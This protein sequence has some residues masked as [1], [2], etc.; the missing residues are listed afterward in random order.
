[1]AW[2]REIFRYFSSFLVR[3]YGLRWWILSH[4]QNKKATRSVVRHCHTRTKGHIRIAFFNEHAI[5]RYHRFT[6]T[7]VK[8]SKVEIK[9]RWLACGDVTIEKSHN[10][11]CRIKWVSTR[12]KM[13]CVMIM[14]IHISKDAYRWKMKRESVSKP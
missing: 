14:F 4:R 7:H 12:H 5:E 9:K 10:K 3:F 8:S 6:N 11:L 1:M 13:V 2:E